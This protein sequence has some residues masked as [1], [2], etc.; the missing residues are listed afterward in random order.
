MD[1]GL[2]TQEL[3]D[4]GL[5]RRLVDAGAARG[6]REKADVKQAEL[7]RH[8]GIGRSLCNHWEAG[9]RS[10]NGVAGAKYGGMLRRWLA[11]KPEPLP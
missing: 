8:C 2:S 5:A 9:R 3:D 11:A 10:P 1:T 6:L 4:L 7:A